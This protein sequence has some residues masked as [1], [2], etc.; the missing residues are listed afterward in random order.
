M[1]GEEADTDVKNNLVW[2]YFSFWCGFDNG[3]QE[4]KHK[5]QTIITHLQLV[6]GVLFYIFVLN[7]NIFSLLTSICESKEYII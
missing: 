7:D 3:S 2:P 4:I 6:T 1:T 5:L